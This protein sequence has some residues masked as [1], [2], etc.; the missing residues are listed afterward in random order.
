MSAK[1]FISHSSNDHKAAQTICTALEHRG[2]VCWMASRDV[3]PG[4]NYMDAIVRAKPQAAKGTY[5]RTVT[6]AA[7]MG[8]GIHVDPAQAARLTVS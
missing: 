7:T 5:V 8:P 6:V 2:L 1:V 4:Q 3:G